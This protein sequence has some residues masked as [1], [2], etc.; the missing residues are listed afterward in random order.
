MKWN[1][2]VVFSFVRAPNSLKDF[3]LELVML[4]EL[5]EEGHRFWEQVESVDHHDL[6]LT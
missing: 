5:V 6:D 1:L 4:L 3:G 2:L